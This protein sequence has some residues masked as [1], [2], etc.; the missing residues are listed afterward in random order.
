M[1][2]L[3]A[4]QDVFEDDLTKEVLLKEVNK[5]ITEK[6]TT[7]LVYFV[8]DKSGLHP[9]EVQEIIQWYLGA[10]PE[11][12][13]PAKKLQIIPKKI[14]PATTGSRT[15]PAKITRG[16]RAGE[17]CGTTIRGKGEYCSKHKM[18]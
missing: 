2:V 10:R 16:I 4:I 18:L 5:K 9:H 6:L 13:T 7:D 1:S 17:E 11:V 8:A 14:K 12:V 3:E 15:C